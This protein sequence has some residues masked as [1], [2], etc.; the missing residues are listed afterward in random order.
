MRN[1]EFRISLTGSSV[2][3]PL[4][5]VLGAREGDAVSNDEAADEASA[6]N[7]PGRAGRETAD[8]ARRWWSIWASI[9][10][11]FGTTSRFMRYEQNVSIA[12]DRRS[13]G[14]FQQGAEDQ[15]PH[16]PITQRQHPLAPPT[17]NGNLNTA[18]GTWH[19]DVLAW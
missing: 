13:G 1:E 10:G 14:S 7:R 6:G 2:L 12:Y 4:S 11:R 16:V 5:S 8:V 19:V 3:V 18:S 15:L 17:A 9:L